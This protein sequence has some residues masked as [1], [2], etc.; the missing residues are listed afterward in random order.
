M[1]TAPLR[2]KFYVD[3]HI[4]MTA[5]LLVTILHRID[6]LVVAATL[7]VDALMVA[8]IE[9]CSLYSWEP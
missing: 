3:Y 5:T 7:R 1:M 8:S 6:G 9:A 4:I 2:K